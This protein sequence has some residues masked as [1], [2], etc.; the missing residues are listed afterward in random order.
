[1]DNYNCTTTN[2]MCPLPNGFQP[3]GNRIC[4]VHGPAVWEPEEIADPVSPP[5][6]PEVVLEL[7][8]FRDGFLAW[9]A[10][11]IDDDGK[12]PETPEIQAG[13]PP[14]PMS[15]LEAAVENP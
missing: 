13:S 1:M 7:I 3:G 14:E 15:P 10:G 12:E 11:E 9:E 8:A 6:D 4:C 5:M 2:C